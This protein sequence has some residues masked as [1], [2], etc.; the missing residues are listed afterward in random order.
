MATLDDVADALYALKPDEFSAAR[1]AEVRKARQAGDRDLAKEVGQLR[2][3]TQSAW[4]VNLLWRDQHEVMEQLFELA[5]ELGRAQAEAAGS[6]LRALTQ[7][8][9]QLENALLR[10]A[11]ELAG[12]EGV[13]ISDS[14]TREAQETLSAA[15]ATPEVADEVRTG[16]LVKPASYAG[17]GALPGSGPTPRPRP[18]PAAPSREPIDL[19]EAQRARE[20]RDTAERARQEREAAQRKVE[21]A[22]QAAEVAN[23]ALTQATRARD[24]ARTR[25]DDLRQRLRGL[26]EQ[27]QRLESEVDDAERDSERAERERDE[28][29]ARHAAALKTLA[30][31]QR[32]L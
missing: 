32:A 11:V 5:R 25:R 7:Q 24:A 21:Q 27:L 29:E 19:R 12:A 26:R 23:A 14:T 13:N 16:R 9:R 3:P 18:A 20:E 4:L 6:E 10:R 22:E 17:F 1:D 30:E 2:K 15:L 28:A 31:A 8:R